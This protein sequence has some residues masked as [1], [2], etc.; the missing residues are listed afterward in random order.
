M[1]LTCAVDG[2][3][4]DERCSSNESPLKHSENLNII[5]S[6]FSKVSCYKNR[7]IN[8]SLLCFNHKK[9]NNI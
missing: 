8:P 5:L 7:L 6:S 9:T 2:S 3:E 4:N 1:Y